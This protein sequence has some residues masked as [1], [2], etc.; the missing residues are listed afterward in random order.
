MIRRHMIMSAAAATLALASC[1]GN[2]DDASPTPTPTGSPTPTPTASPTYAALP[3]AGAVEFNTLSAA[4]TYTGDP[5]TGAVTLGAASTESL[6]TRVR[7]AA[8]N[9]IAAGTF[10]I[11]ENTEESRF[12][13]ANLTTA[14]A[15]SQTEFTFRTTDTATAGKFSQAEFL[16]NVIPTQVTS[17]AGLQLTQASYVNWWRG[18]STTGQKRITSAAYGYL[19]VPT[20]MPTTGTQAYASRVT[21]RLVSVAGGVTSILKV[22]G[23][24]TT[25]VNF[26][27][28]QVSATLTLSTIPAAGGAPVAYGTFTAQGGIPVGNN[29]FTGSFTAGSP[30]NGTL[31]GAFY[32]SQAKEIAISFAGS[33]DNAGANQRLVGV[34]VGKK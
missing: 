4:V 10:V 8:T 20:D 34:I 2:D 13:N 12:V 23:T 18:D 7:L 22:T 16:N 30:L 21:G 11:R 33:G 31:S 15:P 25:S 32:G 26:G 27:T 19:T 29:Q 3:L 1:S 9:D 28:G 6:S 5:A 17:D 14:P 24:V